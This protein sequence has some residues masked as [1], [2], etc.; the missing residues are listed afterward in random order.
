VSPLKGRSIEHVLRRMSGRKR[1]EVTGVT[2][3]MKSVMLLTCSQ[4]LLEKLRMKWAG[5]VARMW[6]LR[7]THKIKSEIPHT[8]RHRREGSSDIDV[9]KIRYE[10]VIYSY[11]QDREQ[12]TAI[13]IRVSLKA[14]MS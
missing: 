12:N 11:I 13:I 3:I 1:Q 10:G 6:K 9:K 2:F 4:I 5:L 14:E 7:N 8:S